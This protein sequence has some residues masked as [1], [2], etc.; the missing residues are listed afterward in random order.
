MLFLL[1][2][3]FGV[4]I[5]LTTIASTARAYR[6]LPERIPMHFW[7]D[8]TI[9]GYGPRPMA[10]FVVALQIWL[11]ALFASIAGSWLREGLPASHVLAMAGFANVLLL[12]LWRVQ[13]LIIET[14]L[15]GKNRADLKPFW[16]FFGATMLSALLL[17]KI[18]S[19]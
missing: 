9:N 3:A 11:G 5:V 17:V 15:S 18:V 7:I 10:W 19:S 16:L 13:Q 8:G 1:F 12:L 6:Q 2:A 14:G 4:S